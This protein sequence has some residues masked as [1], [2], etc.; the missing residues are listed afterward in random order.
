M[1]LSTKP[2]YF[3]HIP[4]TAGT[5][6]RNWLLNF[7]AEADFLE[8]YDVKAL[9]Q[10]S[11]KYISQYRFFSGHFGLELNR[12]LPEKPDTITWLRD[13]VAR[14]ISQYNYLRREREML[15]ELFLSYSDF[16][17]IEYLDLVCELSLIE[18][19]QTEV[20][21]TFRLDN[22]QVRYLA[23]DA[24]PTED[25]K[26][27]E[28]ND[29]M[30]ELAKSNLL[31]F[32]H[33]GLCE[34]MQSSIEL[35]CYRAKWLPRK[36]NLQLNRSE[37]SGDAIAATLSEEELAIVRNL[38]K[39]DY[40]LYEFA[41]AEF[42]SRYQDMWQTCLKTKTSY[43][44]PNFDAAR[45]PSLLEPNNQQESSVE[46]LL[47]EFLENNFQY[48]NSAIKRLDRTS[49]RFS[50]FAFPAGWH[51]REYS[52]DLN[53]WLCW[54]GPEPVSYIYA[55]LKAGLSYRIGFWLLRCQAPDIQESLALEIEEVPIRLERI[56]IKDDKGK[57]RTLLTGLIP[58]EL[59]R[60]DAVYTK[61]LFKVNRVAPINSANSSAPRYV[62]FATDGLHIEPAAEPGIIE[63]VIRLNA[64][65]QEVQNRVWYL[66]HKVNEESQALQQSQTEAQQLKA[67]LAQANEQI[68]RLYQ[69]LDQIKEHAEQHQKE[70]N[71][72]KRLVHQLEETLRQ[73][74]AELQETRNALNHAHDQFKQ[75]LDQSQAQLQQAQMRIAAMET[76]K[77]WQVRKAWFRVKKA[78]GLG[79]NE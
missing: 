33:F 14:E 1:A 65:F 72:A 23:G 57:A 6:L 51:P 71:E 20:I 50:D 62:S 21:K 31:D 28:C 61:L 46:R 79:Q 17:A 2:F 36:F 64:T 52:E 39:Y 22:M 4:K 43:F 8:C 32:L 15:R 53:T 29:E 77:F 35:L 27:T 56:V 58:S 40:A 59:I 48:K 45:Y 9:I 42:R 41:K 30:L 44:D 11:P 73:T 26:S 47:T 55:P 76:S 37:K 60:E 12:F 69:D 3:L 54:A 67:D 75:E 74:Q 19:C 16:G 7:F 10:L 78:L 5:S 63:A 25:K 66:D 34:W 13:P 70:L 38:N 18:L 24:P 68:Q 49:I